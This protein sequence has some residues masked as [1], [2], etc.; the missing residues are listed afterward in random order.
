[1][2]RVPRWYRRC[3]QETCQDI[4]RLVASA[5]ESKGGSAARTEEFVP[6]STAE[7]LKLIIPLFP[8]KGVFSSTHLHHN[9]SFLLPLLY[10]T[11]PTKAHYKSLHTH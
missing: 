8:A 7:L 4:S 6:I 1:V 11:Q 3:S 5:R 10:Y 9:N 2:M